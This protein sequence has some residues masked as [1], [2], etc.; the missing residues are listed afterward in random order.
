MCGEQHNGKLSKYQEVKD[1]T[2]W[3]VWVVIVKYSSP[4]LSNILLLFPT[5]TVVTKNKQGQQ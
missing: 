4:T 2:F 5:E 1:S 3:L